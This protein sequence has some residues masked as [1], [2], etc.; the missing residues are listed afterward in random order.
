SQFVASSFDLE[1]LVFLLLGFF[2]F[3]PAQALWP[4]STAAAPADTAATWRGFARI[5]S[6]SQVANGQNS[7]IMPS[8]MIDPTSQF[9]QNTV[10]L[11]CDPSNAWRKDSSALS[12]STMASTS[13]GSG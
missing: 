1:S 7:R 5:F 3:L 9:D 8:V 6:I 2:T 10:R 4:L 12:P 13:G 11:P